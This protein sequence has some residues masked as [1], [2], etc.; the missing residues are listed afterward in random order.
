MRF[1]YPPQPI[2]DYISQRWVR[3]CGREIDAD[4]C[5]WLV[6]PC[7][8]VD[9]IADRFIM[10]LAHDEN[11]RIERLASGAGLYETID[12]MNMSAADLARLRPEIAGF[13]ERT[14]DY[15]L[16]VWSQWCMGFR[17]FGGMLQRIYSRRLQQLNVP[18]R[19][20]DTSRGITSEIL[21]LRDPVTGGVRYTVW[22]RVLKAT[23]H[24]IYS[25]VYTTCTLTNGQRCVKV[26][27]PL[28]RG[29]ATVIMSISVGPNGELHL[30]SSGRRF[31]EPGFYFYLTD[32]RGGHWAK[33]IRSFRERISVFVDDE[34][35]LRADHVLRLW[36]FRA[37]ELHY[38]MT[39]TRAGVMA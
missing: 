35:T 25:G 31:G 21:K 17:P 12:E 34:G 33:Y 28:P 11:L 2:Q 30:E 1:G 14:A 6:G 39:P 5:Q 8:D 13:Y 32:S 36:Q 18:L 24:V 4:Q 22:Y 20:L 15:D 19:P 7:G 16:E 37:L 10:R 26:I 27:F 29:S 23:R 9:L 3:L 38:K